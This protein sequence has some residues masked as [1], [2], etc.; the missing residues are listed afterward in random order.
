[1]TGRARAVKRAPFHLYD[2][3][4]DDE[5]RKKKRHPET[6]SEGDPA[7]PDDGKEAV[8]D[9]DP[10]DMMIGNESGQGRGMGIVKF[11]E[12]PAKKTILKIPIS[13]ITQYFHVGRH[14]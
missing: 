12:C 2:E 4:R 1:V 13:E 5:G 3:E 10:E 7:Y 14:P 11:N 8:S 6:E 9:K